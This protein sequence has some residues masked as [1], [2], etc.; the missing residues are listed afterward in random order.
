MRTTR[1]WC[2]PTLCVALCGIPVSASADNFSFSGMFNSDDQRA[3]FQFVAS[4]SSPFID[5]TSY[6]T[7][8]FVTELSLFGPDTSLKAT[9]PL[10]G[11]DSNNGTGDSQIDTSSPPIAIIVGDKYWVVLTEF[12]NSANGPTFGAGFHEDGNG[13]FTSNFGC[14]PGPFAD[15]NTFSQRT[16][17]WAV[18]INGVASAQSQSAVPEPA[19]LLLLGTTIAGVLAARRF[20]SAR[21]QSS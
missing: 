13:N 18:N 14:G 7:G 16:G 9:T 5:T 11:A 15:C 2:F 10:I 6:S 17:N 19:T 4:A 12:D 3:I 1:S 20:K 21:R 8:G